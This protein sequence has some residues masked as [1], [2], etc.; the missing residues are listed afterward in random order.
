MGR[1][2]VSA[3][4]HTDSDKSPFCHFWQF[5]RGMQKAE[6]ISSHTRAYSAQGMSFSL[7]FFLLLN[8]GACEGKKI[9]DFL[10]VFRTAKSDK[11]ILGG[12]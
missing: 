7:S 8:G 2:G 6:I 9:P 10:Y 12:R 1:L 4:R 11:S 5:K 3:K